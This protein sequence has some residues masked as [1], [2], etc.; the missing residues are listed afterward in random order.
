[1]R[2]LLNTLYVTTPE[3]YLAN[4]GENILVKVGKETRF[5]IPIHNLEDIVCFGYNGASPSAMHLC[6]EKG[7][8][9]SFLTEHGYFLARVSGKVSGNVLLRR[10]QYRWAD[11]EQEKLRIAKRF[12]E[13]KLH[14]SRT[15]LQ[16]ALRDNENAVYA[17]KF[18]NVIVNM[19]NMIGTVEEAHS[20]DTVRGIEGEGSSE[21]FSCFDDLIVSQK[22]SFSFNGRTRRPPVDSVN[23]L[24]SFAYTLLEHE[25]ISALET[26]GLDPQ[27]GY[28][29]TDR[30]GRR[31]LALDLMEELRSFIADRIVL[32]LI[33]RREISGTGFVKMENGAVLMNDETRKT[34]LVSWQNRKR[35]ELT[36]PFLREKVPIGLIPYVQSMLLARNIRGDLDDYPPFLWK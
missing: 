24:L 12:V 34:T 8:G 17:S 30:P 21:Y 29:H 32:S 36:H 35:E 33:N 13:S 2:R 20:I 27:V 3:S 16:R 9:L 5:R 1:M 31:S 6:V 18:E 7:V 22:E 4:E 11:E 23:A 14:N 26:V 25:Y 10:K 19:K 28:L 15:I